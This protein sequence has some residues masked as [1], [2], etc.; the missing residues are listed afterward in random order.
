MAAP[1]Q[2]NRVPTPSSLLSAY[3]D[4]LS[5]YWP[6]G[7]SFDRY[8]RATAEDN[9]ALPDDE[10]A[11]MQAGF[12]DALGEDGVA[13]MARVVWQEQLRV[14]K[15]EEAASSSSLPSSSDQGQRRRQPP[16][17]W[18]KTW[19]KR[20]QGQPWGFVAFRTA[21][22]TATTTTS[23]DVEEFQTRVRE[24]VEIPFDAALEQG[25]PVDAVAEARS[26]FEIRWVEVEEEAE[27]TQAEEGYSRRNIIVADP[28]ERLRARYRT[29][30]ESGSLPPGLFLS[31]FLCASPAA[32]AS[33]L[34]T[35]PK[36]DNNGKKPGTTSPRWRSGA[37]FLL[38]VA[39]EEERGV[40]DDEANKSV[41]GGRKKDWFKPVFKVA[42]EVLVDE[43]WWVVEKQITSLGKL[44]RF[45]REVAV[46]DDVSAAEE[47]KKKEGEKRPGGG[48]GDDDDKQDEEPGY[49]DD[50][51]DDIWWSVHIPPYRMRKRKRVF[52]S[53]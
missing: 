5:S 50:G 46:I 4:A 25:Q 2:D 13:E 37:P 21:T 33:V 42:A 26:T 16:P 44:T 10:R 28:V 3:S 38:A 34:S 23:S 20:Y 32:V 30:R 9:A 24:I 47:E 45:V 15:L 52:T 6:P 18:L 35:S 12:R 36:G 29:M 40:M 48:Y 41:G 11:K 22:T 8:A 27:E 14:K 51:L 17:D 31:I 19:R 1:R 53:E 39:A 49:D 7:W 43:L